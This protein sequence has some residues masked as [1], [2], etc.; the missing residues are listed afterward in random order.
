VSSSGTAR[1]RAR[2]IELDGLARPTNGFPPVV[3]RAFA[4]TA[5]A[6]DTTR[7]GLGQIMPTAVV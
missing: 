3:A 4:D 1:G 2:K 5:A 6:K 7:K